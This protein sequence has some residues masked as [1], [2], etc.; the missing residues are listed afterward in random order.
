MTGRTRYFQPG[1]IVLWLFTLY[2]IWWALGIGQFV[3]GLATIPLVG[4][5]LGR[6]GMRRPPAVALFA[7]YVAWAFFTIVRVDSGGRLLLFGLRYSVYLTSIGLAY[8]V[9]NHLDVARE[10]FIK[11]I[12][13]LWVWA[14][15]GGYLGLLMPDGRLSN[16]P[17]SF[18]LPRSLRSNEFVANLVRPRFA[19]VRNYFGI[20][21]PRPST[22]FAFTNEWGGNVGLLTPF[23][24][25]ATLY[26]DDPRRRRMGVIGLVIGVPPMIFSMN[27]GLWISLVAI[28]VVAAVRNFV[29][30]RT[31]PLRTLSIAVGV[32]AAVLFVTP[33]GRVVTGRLEEGEAGA[34]SR[35]YVEAFR[36]ALES[37]LLGWGGP[38]PSADPFAPAVG[39][40][41]HLWFAL[42][43][44]GFVAAGLYVLF[45]TWAVVTVVRR[46]DPVSI[47]MA[48]V[49]VVG[50]LQMFFYNMFSGSLPLILVA[51]AL[52]LR[53]SG[54]GRDLQP[55]DVLSSAESPGEISGATRVALR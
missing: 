19:Q 20:D 11:W 8:Y 24:V 37:P 38:R 22:L 42:F 45:M 14:I 18:V 34:R 39:T 51:L 30:G 10:V 26:S 49:V 27:R 55:G 52:C 32:F 7:L 35:I 44:H 1:W 25:A 36:G 31:R 9:Y 23:F 4:W 5:A 53:E 6:R 28:L 46:S 3:W 48:S 43:S 21:V 41:G 40:H 15:M 47:M 16:T 12:A 50:A 2:P 54:G 17:A 33:L 13:W 29:A